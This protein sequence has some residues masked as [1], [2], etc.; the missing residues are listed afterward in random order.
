MRKRSP[1]CPFASNIN[2]F[3]RRKC[4]SPKSNSYKNNLI[5]CLR[6]NIQ[7]LTFDVNA[8]L[9]RW[10]R[11]R[12]PYSCEALTFLFIVHCSKF[13]KNVFIDLVAAI[14]L[15]F[16]GIG[17]G[18]PHIRIIRII[19]T[20][21]LD[22]IQINYIFLFVDNFVK[23]CSA[24]TGFRL[25][26]KFVYAFLSPPNKNV[27]I[28]NW[29]YMSGRWFR[30]VH[31]EWDIHIQLRPTLFSIKVSGCILHWM[32]DGLRHPPWIWRVM[33]IKY[34]IKFL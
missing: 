13:N 6:T 31:G 7:D 21:Q 24:F 23:Y 20:I 8:R 5:N 2:A 18:A 30:S 27:T 29:R 17:I 4:P 14:I 25:F 34:A 10:V 1:A 3:A 12:A 16:A 19:K 33:E 11:A 28:S 22:F 15:F 26:W 9:Q 32:D